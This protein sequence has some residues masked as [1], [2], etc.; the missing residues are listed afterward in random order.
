[1]STIGIIAPSSRGE[2]NPEN[3][4]ALEARGHSVVIHPQC[5]LEDHQS[6]GT[7]AQRAEAVMDVFRDKH[8]DIIMAAQGGNRSMHIL[9]HLD[10][11]VISKNAKPFISFSDGTALLNAIY[12]KTGLTGFHG[13]TL[14]RITRAGAAE[15]DQ[16]FACLSSH[17]N[18]VD[19]SAS[20]VLH[21]GRVTAPM[22][23]G[24]LSVFASLC[25]TPYMPDY[26]GKI[27]FLEDI[28]DQ[29]SRYDRML[30]QLRLAGVFDQA[31]AVIFGV[32]HS[33]GDS[34]VTPF[35]FSVD[36]ILREHT[37]HLKVPVLI[38][39]PFGHKGPLPTFPIGGM[40]TLDAGTKTLFIK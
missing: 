19:L 27:V 16:M 21:G 1:M 38:N 35:G 15:L 5:Y 34:S 33:E 12:A 22:V 28:G 20:T 13:P 36:D 6:A 24:N 39:A 3:I 14:S 7:A 23:G 30:A 25:G 9:P 40:A 29:L 4:A 8:I 26:R 37:A 2:I 32:M 11:D 31:A 10:F 17:P 18:T